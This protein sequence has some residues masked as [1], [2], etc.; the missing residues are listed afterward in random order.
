[1]PLGA[2]TAM[3]GI[4]NSISI[5]HGSQGC[6]TY[7]RRHMATHYN[8]PVDIA[9]SSLTENGTVYGGEANLIQGLKNLIEIYHPEV[10]GVP[11]TCLAETIGEDIKRIIENFYEQYPQYQTVKIIPIHSPGYSGSQAEGYFEALYQI[12]TNLE[13]NTQGHKKINVITSYI[14]PADTRWLKTTFEKFG[15]EI[16]LLPDLSTNLDAGFSDHYEKLP[17]QGT[18]IDE[19]SK[20]AGASLTL[21]ITNLQL[22]HSVGEFLETQY[23]VPCERI[24]LPI[25]LKDCDRFYQ[26]LARIAKVEIPKELVEERKR[27]LDAMIDSHKFNAQGRATLFGE[28]DQVISMTRLC[29]ENGIVPVVVT[30]GAP[31]AQFAS[32][33]EN[34]VSTA[35]ENAFVK[36]YVILDDV[37]F[38]DI[39]ELSLQMKSN[40]LIGNSD[41]RRIEGE[42]G[43]PLV[44]RGFPIHDRVGGQRLRMLG[45]EGSLQVLDEITNA[46]I[47]KK[48]EGYRTSIY[49]KYYAKPE[50][51]SMGN[52]TIEEKTKMHP[53]YNC[54]AHKYARIHLPV[55][56]RCNVQCNY[57]VRKFD[58]PNE[59]RP[60]VT[61]KVLT[62]QEAFE[63]YKKIKEKM[64]NLTVVG[65][66]G[67]GDALANW[68]ETKQTLELIRAYD[69]DVTFC[70]STNGLMLPR[71]ANELVQLGVSHITVTMNAIDPH[72][73][74]KI[75]KYIHYMGQ[76]YEGDAAGAI[77]ISNQLNGLR[78]LIAHGVICKVNIVTLKG[79]NDLHI[80][81]VVQKVKEIGGFITNIMPHLSVEGSAFEE[82]PKLNEKEIHKLRTECEGILK[83]MYHCKQCRADAV[84]TLDNDQSIDIKGFVD[85]PKNETTKST[86]EESKTSRF[87]VASKD[88]V[89]VDFHFG[90]AKAFYIYDYQEGEVTF[91]EQ[92][93]VEKYC[94]GKE[95]QDEE[96]KIEKMIQTISDCQGILSMRIGEA[97]KRKLREMGIKVVTTY[98]YVKDA[99][100]KA[101]K[102]LNE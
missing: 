10:V 99:V 16:I 59:S 11:T 19:I 62:P 55:A 28:A 13:M 98:D 6:S 46:I 100:L 48:E 74:G 2:V 35:A 82:L 90:Q 61:T 41:A 71:Y 68:D 32:Y 5:L 91:V 57:C 29:C 15:L 85:G 33:V 80:P 49:E 22:P 36:E 96:D 93:F 37:D 25:G 18:S 12:V 69:K 75:Y 92:R 102:Q 38:K 9:S 86:L 50:D 17:H 7:I 67:P 78:I 3:Y 23:N 94:Q 26:T 20:M 56:P 76:R 30:T 84:G 44:R 43:I 97:P 72:I 21:E 54:G 40:L 14:S 45:Y 58:C 89:L 70:L 34:D 66:A 27:Y 83:Q 31:F 47:S 73:A 77:M 53:C 101:G 79:I 1:M 63:R 24:N 51:V 65:I 64:P 4:Q 42:Y 87:A 60:G 39:E 95:C 81:Q 88:G 8:E 52:T